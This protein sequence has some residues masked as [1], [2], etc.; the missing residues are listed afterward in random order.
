MT[1]QEI[2]E[3]CREDSFAYANGG[4]TYRKEKDV[5]AIR[6]LRCTQFR[7]GCPARAKICSNPPVF[8]IIKEHENHDASESQIAIRKV[9][10]KVNRKVENSH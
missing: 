3:D 8:S 10:T 6:Y 5:K 7:C 2:I 4:H 1:N 9:L